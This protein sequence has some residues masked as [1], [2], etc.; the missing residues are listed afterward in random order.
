MVNRLEARCAAALGT[1]LQ[2]RGIRQP[3]HFQ[4]PKETT[5]AEDRA[6]RQEPTH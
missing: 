3:R 1:G 4:T 2:R 6:W 5:A